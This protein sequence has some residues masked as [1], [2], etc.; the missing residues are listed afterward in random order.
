[1]SS[2]KADAQARRAKIAEMRAKAERERRRSAIIR[3]S[4]IMTG[5]L[6]A[7]GG[8]TALVISQ[9]GGSSAAAIPRSG[10]TTAAAGRDTAPPWPAPGDPSARVAAAGLPMLGTEGTALHIHAHLDV[11]VDGKA[12]TVPALLGIDEPAQKIS[13]LHTHDTTGVVHIE[14]PTKNVT[15]T[16]GQVMT[17]WNVTLSANQIGGLK[18]GGGKTLQAYVNGKPQS[19]DPAALTLHAHD[20]IALVYGAP[21]SVA[22][23]PGS[24]KW[25]NG[26]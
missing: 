10:A 23:V 5:V 25:T 1:M 22:K 11:F 17:E 3:G 4:L 19:G 16:L 26:L 9:S 20:Q 15:F 13:P 6:A 24:Y 12:V 21:G 7:A 18:A 2:K 14:S 8:L